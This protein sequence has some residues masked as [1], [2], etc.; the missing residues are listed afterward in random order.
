MAN[1]VNLW[2][3]QAGATGKRYWLELSSE[4][5]KSDG[6]MVED[7]AVGWRDTLSFRSLVSSVKTKPHRPT[8][9]LKFVRV[10]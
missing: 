9:L 8:F 4:Y 1:P 7:G 10:A 3:R 5:P 6:R 2:S